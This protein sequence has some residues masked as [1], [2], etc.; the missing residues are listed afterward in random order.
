M[1][2][3][4]FEKFYISYMNLSIMNE[5]RGQL[6][7]FVILGVVIF[8]GVVGLFLLRDNFILNEVDEVSNARG[9]LVS[10]FENNFEGIINGVGIRENDSYFYDSGEILI[11]G[12]DDIEKEL[13]DFFNVG[14]LNCIYFYNESYEGVS[15]SYDDMDIDV[16]TEDEVIRAVV[17]LNLF[18][19]VSGIIYSIDFGKKDIL[20]DSDLKKMYEVSDFFVNY[21]SENDEWIP[22]SKVISMSEEY[23]LKFNYEEVFEE[24]IVIVSLVSEL[25]RFPGEFRF[26]NK[27]S[28]NYPS[29][30]GG[31]I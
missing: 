23:D 8:G 27:F 16:K 9:E 19:N 26:Y 24:N 18:V 25:E 15:L 7:L 31:L 21:L 30:L 6:T 4:I 1:V 10:C 28:Y 5:K 20:I 12:I 17:N 13:E 22:L 3:V 2:L 14:V 29:D 11:L